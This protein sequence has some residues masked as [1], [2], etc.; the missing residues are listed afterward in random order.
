MQLFFHTKYRA[1]SLVELL[2]AMAIIGVL[3]GLVV[4]GISTAQLNSRDAQR[5]QKLA[6]IQIAITDY[7]GRTN[8]YPATGSVA[9]TATQLSFGTATVPVAGPAQY[10]LGTG[11]GPTGKVSNASATTYCYAANDP[12]YVYIV[13]AKLESGNGAWAYVGEVTSGNYLPGATGTTVIAGCVI[14]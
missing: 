7:Q 8:S 6:D 4:F 14:F 12:K 11:A 3:L 2:V 13:G 9:P 10:Q 1:F 5:R